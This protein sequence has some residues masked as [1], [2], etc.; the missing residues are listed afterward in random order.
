MLDQLETVVSRRSAIFHQ[1]SQYYY[2]CEHIRGMSKATMTSKIYTINN[3]I[4]E[5]RLLDLRKI[6]NEHIYAWIDQQKLRGNS[7]RSI[8]NRL[9]HLK[10]M[11]RWQREMN[12]AMPRLKLALIGKTAEDPP[13]KR[14]FSR[15]DIKRVLALATPLE[16][17]LVRLCF[18]CGL[19]ISEL[20]SICT[21]DIQDDRITI[22]GKGHKRR[23]VFL[24]PEVKRALNH[25]IKQNHP[26][27]YLWPSPIN[28]SAP[29]AVCTL[30][31]Y[32]QQAFARAGFADF[33][34]HDLR[35][36]YATDLK[37]LGIPTRKIQASLGHA[38]EAITERYLSDLDGFDLREVYQIKYRK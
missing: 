7:G 37:L 3:F 1:V 14:S 35:H 19:R 8:N 21:W 9:A 24:C 38:T 33:C 28:T 31:S 34:P 22:F 29:L 16:W 5:S 27:G 11:L 10:A 12:L 13:R 20:Q 17:L 6:S 2:F 15:T 4:H 26:D 23:Y 25:W 30:R 32:L 18:D 36:S